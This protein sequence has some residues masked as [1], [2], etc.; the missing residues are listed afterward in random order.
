MWQ[1]GEVIEEAVVVVARSGSHDEHD[2]RIGDY[3][4]SGKCR[5]FQGSILMLE[6]VDVGCSSH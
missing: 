3:D 1:P 4:L 6:G 5:L 2:W